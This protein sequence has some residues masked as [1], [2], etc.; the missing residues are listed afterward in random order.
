M[1]L[2]AGAAGALGV[3]P[4]AADGPATG[5]MGA[6]AAGVRGEGQGPLFVKL[7]GLSQRHFASDEGRAGIAALLG[8][9]PAPWVPER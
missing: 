1:R 4:A 6:G 3:G 8:K 5:G 2:R 9:R 7:E